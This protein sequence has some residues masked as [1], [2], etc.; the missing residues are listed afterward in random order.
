MTPTERT[1]DASARNNGQTAFDICDRRNGYEPCPDC[2]ADYGMGLTNADGNVHVQC[3]V[4]GFAGPGAALDF[5][6]ILAADQAAFEAWNALPRPK[7]APG[8][9][10]DELEAI[11]PAIR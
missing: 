7:N 11:A 1:A 2:A 5:S 8:E 3:G 9:E 10:S 6:D 4:C